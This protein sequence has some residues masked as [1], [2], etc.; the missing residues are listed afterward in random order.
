MIYKCAVKPSASGAAELVVYQDEEPLSVKEDSVLVDVERCA[1]DVRQVAQTL[2]QGRVWEDVNRFSLVGYAAQVGQEVDG[3]CAGDRVI[4]FGPSVS[5]VALPAHECLVVSK[6][7]DADRVACWA[8]AIELIYHLRRVRIEV[9]ES[10]LVLGDGLTGL[11]V[12]QLAFA[13]GAVVA[14]LANLEGAT[15]DPKAD[16][17]IDT[18]GSIELLKD[19]MP[20]VRDGG[21]VLLLTAQNQ[22]PVDF[23]FYPDVHRRSLKF[24]V[25]SIGGPVWQTHFSAD[26]RLHKD[27][28]FVRHL[29]GTRRLCTEYLQR[30]RPRDLKNKKGEPTPLKPEASALL[31]EW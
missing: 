5:R 9:G 8:L 19:M 1:L 20:F 18:S 21:R 2:L 14:E 27:T 17:L 6:S 16:V 25:G 11:L 3:V 26:I 13:A 7:V 31:V 4:A 28:E 30:V 23:D 22:L 10:V 12:A 24:L 29:F 15:S